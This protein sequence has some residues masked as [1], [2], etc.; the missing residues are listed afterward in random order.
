M[1]YS[2]R[3]P[4]LAL[5]LATTEKKPQPI[6]KWEGVIDFTH[7]DILYL[8][9]L[10]IGSFLDSAQEWLNQKPERQLVFLE[11]DLAQFKNFSHKAPAII[12]HP[13]VH[14]KWIGADLDRVLEQCAAEF[15]AEKIDVVALKNGKRE[16]FRKIRLALFR[17]SLL[18]YSVVA[19]N[20][21]GHL[22]HKNIMLNLQKL[23]HCSYVNAWKD[24]WKGKPVVICGA[25]PSLREVAPLLK[26]MRDQAVVIGCGSALSALAH[27]KIRPHLGIACDP[28]EREYDCLKNCTF[29]DLPLLFGSRLCHKVFQLFEG[30][31]GYIRSGSSTPF[32]RYIEEK[33]GLNEPPLGNDLGREAL[34]V[35][36]LALSLA[37]F[38][39]CN[40]II[41]AGVDLAYTDRKLYANGV[42][43]ARMPE[44]KRAGERVLRRKN[45]EGKWVSTT[46]KWVMEQETIDRFAQ[47]HPETVFLNISRGLGFKAIP[48]A[49]HIELQSSL[50]DDQTL[51]HLLQKRLPP[52]NGP[53]IKKLFRQMKQSLCR[54][55]ELI[56]QLKEETG[57]KAVLYE[58]ELQEEI[59]YQLLLQ[60]PLR[61][62][63]RINKTA[64][65][66]SYLI[67]AARAYLE[68]L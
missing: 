28:N 29:R 40:P 48:Y 12:N 17:K 47:N 64:S 24:A 36:T 46:T 35:T 19:E 30:P 68:L 26:K 49:K 57:G 27:L 7:I 5:L 4:D 56:E 20:V 39:G 31:L 25:G 6:Q 67:E 2:L 33:L 65:P 38:W 23:P 61:D 60:A 51:T 15:P 45:Q 9:G 53:S 8:Y 63:V 58:V 59:S 22:L 13:Q 10:A 32:E 42:L 14:L 37:R 55:I 16:L 34:S 52:A 44:D 43:A 50:H 11:D 62:F 3:Y 1:P 18:W 54:S 41:L 21:A 66:W